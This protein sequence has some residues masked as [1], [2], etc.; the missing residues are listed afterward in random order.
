GSLNVFWL[1]LMGVLSGSG[2]SLVLGLGLLLGGL[3]G[4]HISA[5]SFHRTDQARFSILVQRTVSFRRLP[6]VHLDTW[7]IS[8]L[9][10]RE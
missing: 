3:A 2:V 4:F 8:G 10:A 5:V 1:V 6:D 7:G 9:P